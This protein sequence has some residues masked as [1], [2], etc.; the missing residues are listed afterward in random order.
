MA[1]TSRLIDVS[2]QLAHGQF[3]SSGQA[4]SAGSAGSAGTSNA[5]SG[6]MVTLSNLRVSAKLSK[7]GAPGMPQLAL[8]V[9]G[10]P[11]SLMNQLSTIG[12][13]VEEVQKN[14]V[15]VYAGET[16]PLAMVFKGIIRNA[17]VDIQRAPDAAFQVM[18]TGS[19]YAA[20][21]SIAPTSINGS[22]DV[23]QLFSGLSGKA[24]LLS[25]T[26]GVNLKLKDPYLWGSPWSQMKQCADAAGV[27]LVIDNGTCA[28]WTPDTGRQGNTAIISADTGMIAYP[29]YVSRGIQVRSL[30]NRSIKFG[31]VA[32][33]QSE[34][35]PSGLP[36]DGKWSISM[37]EYD[38]ESLVPNGHW[39]MTIGLNKLGEPNKV[40]P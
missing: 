7:V 18:A 24:S 8:T 27:R 10:M 34:V 35:R 25:E 9:Y 20:A 11:L 3:G 1:F 28:I 33:V 16:R 38:L 6:N 15:I 40:W 21:Q 5:G 37:I 30:F 36:P 39:F 32:Q 17:W 12:L 29:T 23:A 13:A 4:S 22:A 14:T 26:N 31:G 2:F 19:T